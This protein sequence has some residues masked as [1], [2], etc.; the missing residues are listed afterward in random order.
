M[1]TPNPVP[2]NQKCIE[3]LEGANPTTTINTNGI[4]Q[5]GDSFQN[6]S[7][8]VNWRQQVSRKQD[9]TTN[10][11]RQWIK[12]SPMILLA[13]SVTPSWY[14]G[15]SADL[16]SRNFMVAIDPPPLVDM[17]DDPALADV[18]LSRLKRRLS[19]NIGDFSAMAPIAELH[20]MRG[21]IRNLAELGMDTFKMLADI[22]R[23][24][25]R[26]A[27]KLASKVWL[28]F[29]FGAKPLMGAI[30]DASEAIDAYLTRTDHNLKV[31]GTASRRKFSTFTS[32]ST[33]AFRAPMRRRYLIEQNL[34]YRY[35]G[36]FDLKLK[37]GNNYGIGDHFGFDWGELPGVAWEL[38]PFSWAF[39]YFATV[40][41][42]LG[43]TF[44]LPN[45]SLIY[46]MKQA[47]YTYKAT[48]V[49]EHEALY[50]T[51]FRQN[52]CVPGFLDLGTFNRTKLSAIPRRSL[53]IKSVDEVGRNAANKLLNLAS[54]LGGSSNFRRTGRL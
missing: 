2:I 18:A 36:A 19:D 24:K 14:T 11:S 25:G 23:T 53:R 52:T 10:Y 21:F 47:R 3:W 33:G 16:H 29:S 49:G 6:G 44:E 46:L 8:N 12:G 15:F 54:I 40:G 31:S 34:S 22:K 28:N 37:S 35:A 41:S 5:L 9:A 20:E 1:N 26:S 48:L 39:D 38:V 45:G 50:P 17:Y 32:S 13:E 4:V 27:A 30:K 42:Y 51:Y 7:S 43:D